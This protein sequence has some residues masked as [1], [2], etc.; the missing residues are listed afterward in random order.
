MWLA[1][2]VIY[3][4]HV[5]T[6]TAEGTFD[7]A[8]ERLDH[9]A[10]LGVDLVELLPVAAFNG[11]RGWGY[12]GVCWYAPHEPYGGPDGLKQD[13][14]G[15]LY[16]A[17]GLN[18]PNPPFEPAEDKKGGIYVFSP[19]GKLLVTGAADKTTQLWDAVTREPLGPRWPYQGGDR[20]AAHPVEQQRRANEIRCDGVH[21]AVKKTSAE[22]FE[23]CH[24]CLALNGLDRERCEALA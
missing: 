22:R 7:A 20:A 15:R 16:V 18:K 23:L 13:R 19:E 1:G 6:F 10:A 24:L 11:E 5:G 3:E 17:A 2:S 9:L 4:L 21:A 14:Q 8:I 12:D